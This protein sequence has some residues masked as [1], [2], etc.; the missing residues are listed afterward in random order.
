MAQIE[1]RMVVDSEWEEV[2]FLQMRRPDRPS[3]R[4]KKVMDE[5]EFGVEN[6]EKEGGFW[7][8]FV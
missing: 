5:M 6:K 2:E 7:D 8:E 1:N 3:K 4:L